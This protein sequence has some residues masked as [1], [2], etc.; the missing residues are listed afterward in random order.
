MP[1]RVPADLALGL[2]AVVLLA[3]AL[4]TFTWTE[5][6]TFEFAGQALNGRV[7]L[8]FAAATVA[9][10]ASTLAAVRHASA[11][12]RW[13]LVPVG[14]VAWL[15]LT[16]VVAGQPVRES[17][18]TVTRW[19]L[20]VAALYLGWTTAS[21]VRT[22]S[23]SGAP[24]R[25]ERVV[26]LLAIATAAIP[27]IAGV[28]ELVT[29]SAPLLNGARRISGTMAGHPAAYSLVLTSCAMLVVPT[30]LAARTRRARILLWGF[31]GLSVLLILFTS[32]R[33]TLLIVLGA[34]T[35]AAAALSTTRREAI[36][37]LAVGAAISGV[38]VLAAVPFFQA[39]LTQTSAVVIG[40]GGSSPGASPDPGSETVIEVDNSTL[41]RLRIHQRV[42][43]YVLRSPV[44]GHGPGSFDRLYE[45]DT[46]QARVAAHD[47]LALVAVETG[48][49]GLALYLAMLVAIA[50]HLRPSLW[51]SPA[52]GRLAVATGSAWLVITLGATFHNPGY[53]PEVSLLPFLLAGVATGVLSLRSAP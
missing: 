37:R 25:A 45:A 36:V 48:L 22:Q 3:V 43:D 12:P 52:L 8:Y 14:F 51:R 49:P 10:L 42:V 50:W 46:G 4:P 11:R 27:I 40:N 23:T 34:A 47:D 18:P 41:L 32:T 17:A 7:V 5:R 24:E 13:M 53:F 21:A 35:V 1:R 44:M 9:A 28:L 39:R 2:V 31:L 19:I 15:I 16:A 30:M 33:L 20:Y 6:L 29:G 38:V 26:V